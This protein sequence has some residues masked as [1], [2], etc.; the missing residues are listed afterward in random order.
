MELY[1]VGEGRELVFVFVSFSYFK[2]VFWKKGVV[3]VIME[4]ERLS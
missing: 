1:R 2:R 3:E 4:G